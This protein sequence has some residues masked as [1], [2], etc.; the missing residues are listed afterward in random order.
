VSVCLSFCLSV[1]LS[2]CLAWKTFILCGLSDVH[3][4]IIGTYVFDPQVVFGQPW[5][6]LGWPCGLADFISFIGI[7]GAYLSDPQAVFGHRWTLFSWPGSRI[8]R[9]VGFHFNGF[10]IYGPGLWNQWITWMHFQDKKQKKEAKGNLSRA[11]KSYVFGIFPIFVPLGGYY[12]GSLTKTGYYVIFLRRLVNFRKAE[13]AFDI[14]FHC[15]KRI[16]HI[17]EQNPILWFS[18]PSRKQFRKMLGSFVMSLGVLGAPW[19]RPRFSIFW[20]HFQSIFG[21]SGKGGKRD[22]CDQ[23][24]S[25]AKVLYLRSQ[26]IV[27][28]M[29]ICWYIGISVAASTVFN[30]LTPFSVNFWGFR[31]TRE[32]GP[33]GPDGLARESLIS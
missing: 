9:P 13:N 25:R 10:W 2:V 5:A 17:S 24:A 3:L 15:D 18:S 27:E 6:S 12:F 33:V 16:S 31:P 29:A 30:I 1:C 14:S 11:S 23:M 32:K 19:R 8:L 20:H 4:V 21:V 7:L 26:W 22:Q 28:N